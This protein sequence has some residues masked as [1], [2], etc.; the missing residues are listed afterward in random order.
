MNSDELMSIKVIP[1]DIKKQS[2]KRLESGLFHTPYRD[3]IRLFSCIKN[4]DLKKL[5]FELNQLGIQNITVGQ[6]SENDLQQSKYMAVSFIT[7]ATRYAIQ[8]GLD[9]N[10]AYEYSDEFIRNID[11]AKTKSAVNAYIVDGAVELTNLISKERKNL[12]YSPHIRRCISYINKNLDK[13]LTVEDIAKHCRLSPD[14]LSHIFKEEIGVNLS[15]YITKQKLELA[16]T[17][18]WENYDNEKICYMLGFSSQSH[19]ISLFKKEYGI[20]PRE[21]EKSINL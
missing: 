20:T 4:G 7:L 21:Y 2:Y 18:I 13:R 6:M 12:T 19:F 17:L 1:K 15:Y 11:K 8:G 16:K 5:V 10:K 14:Y 9:E 3:E